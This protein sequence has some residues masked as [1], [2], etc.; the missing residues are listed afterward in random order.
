VIDS[1]PKA[2]NYYT[3]GFLMYQDLSYWGN[4]QMITRQIR[5]LFGR[6]RQR[7]H[8]ASF[9]KI[10]VSVALFFQML[11]SIGKSY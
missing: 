5:N 11:Q 9:G 2:K 8:P 10:A 4:H 7:R 6:R 3:D 1:A